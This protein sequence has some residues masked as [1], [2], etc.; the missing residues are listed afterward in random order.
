M[1]EYRMTNSDDNSSIR[2]LTEGETQRLVDFNLDG[3]GG[4][5]GSSLN[6]K[7]SSENPIS[8]LGLSLSE[9]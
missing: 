7:A 1:K 5:G 3:L 9:K 2:L 4:S 8:E 6:I